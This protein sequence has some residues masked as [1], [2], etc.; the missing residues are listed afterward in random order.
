MWCNEW[1]R[2]TLWGSLWPSNF[3]SWFYWRSRV[4][5]CCS[6]FC[7]INILNVCIYLI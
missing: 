3:F 6:I 4:R 1:M 7:V 2:F 5:F